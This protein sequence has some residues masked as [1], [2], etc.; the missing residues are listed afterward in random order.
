MKQMKPIEA[1]VPGL[2]VAFVNGLILSTKALPASISTPEL[3]WKINAR[4]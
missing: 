2:A 4:I 3:L 1:V